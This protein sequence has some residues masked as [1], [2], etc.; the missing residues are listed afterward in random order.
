MTP[1]EAAAF[2][3]AHDNYLILTHVRPDGDTTGCAAGLCRALRQTGKRA[4]VLDNPGLTELFAP[5]LDGLTIGSEF[6]PETVVSVDI[7]A[8]SLFFE[9]AKPYLDRVDL[10]I[11]H[12]PSQEFFA[13]QTCLDSKHASCG[14]L[15]Y[16][17][18]RQFASITPEIGEALY[19]ALSTDCG[20]FQYSNTDASVH[21]AAAEL[22]DSGFDPYPVNRRFFRTKTF[23]RLKLESLLTAGMELR[24]G[25]Q[26]AL[27]FLTRAM[28][29]EVGAS[30]RDMDDISAFV[31]QIEGVK[32]G[33]TLKET[34][35]G[36]VKISLRTDPGDLNASKVCALLGGGG[37]AAAAGAMLEGGMESVRQA[38]IDAIKAVRNG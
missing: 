4:F 26:T 6:V 5:Y 20:C 25:G 11:D 33:V 19:V 37:H 38:V 21:R 3:T 24:D 17:I 29:E 13:E 34:A 1:Q 10:A 23:K 14:Q 16:D 36:H 32:N 15:I 31:G 18:V 30:E 7:A 9:E 27:V 35:D 8:K 22:M 28:I 12:H 2:L